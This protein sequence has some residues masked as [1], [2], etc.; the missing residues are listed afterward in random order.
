VAHDASGK[1]LAGARAWFRGLLKVDKINNPPL[2]LRLANSI[3]RL[4][5]S[6]Y[7]IRDI[8]VNGF[9]YEPDKL[10]VAQDLWEV[11]RW[12]CRTYGTTLAISFDPR[13]PARNAVKLKPWHQPRPKV[14]VTIQGP[15]PIDRNR[16][17]YNLGRV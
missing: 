16:L 1:L 4:I 8:S 7:V 14:V 6:D 17:L 15:T 5:P 13:D 10:H 12:Q 2:P 3:L 11:M 9:W